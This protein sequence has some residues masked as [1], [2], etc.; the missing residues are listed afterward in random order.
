MKIEDIK[1]KQKDVN[2]DVKVI[3]DEMDTKEYEGRK[4]KTVAVAD[5][6]STPEKRGPTALLDL[7]D[8]DISR[9]KFQDKI[10]VTNAYAKII[11]TRRGEQP[12]ITYGFDGKKLI[13]SY[14]L[15]TE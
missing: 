10:R 7:F 3:Y 14:E 2:I 15:I 4:S 12:L 5:A 9:F 13:G 8:D 1:D 6:D 11:T